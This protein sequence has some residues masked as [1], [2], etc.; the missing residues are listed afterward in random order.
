MLEDFEFLGDDLSYEIVVENTN[1]ILDMVEEIEVIIDTGG[2]PFSPNSAKVRYS[3]TLSGRIEP[4][5]MDCTARA[6]Y[7]M[8]GG[9]E[10]RDTMTCC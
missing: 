4:F 3:T 8:A 10:V 5:S 2:I 7:V 9:N 1:K 6:A